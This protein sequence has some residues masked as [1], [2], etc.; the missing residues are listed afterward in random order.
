MC[1]C[2]RLIRSPV[3]TPRKG[4]RLKVIAT[5][6]PMQQDSAIMAT[7][8]GLL[9]SINLHMMSLLHN[10]NHCLI[11]SL[12]APIASH[13]R[14]KGVKRKLQRTDLLYVVKGK[15]NHPQETTPAPRIEGAESPHG[16]GH[17]VS[18]NT[19]EQRSIST[20]QGYRL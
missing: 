16:S 14:S 8:H 11:V 4:L 3:M 12:I 20:T 7:R 9:F 10:V 13:Q 18:R 5:K 1:T 19:T 6:P 2:T 15:E 17:G